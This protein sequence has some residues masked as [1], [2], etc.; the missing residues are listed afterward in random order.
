MPIAGAQP[1]TPQPTAGVA[2]RKRPWYRKKRFMIPL[3]ALIILGMVGGAGAYLI[4]QRFSEFQSVSEPE[5]ESGAA[6]ALTE[7]TAAVTPATDGSIT[8]LMMGVDARDG[9]AIDIGVRPDSLSV[10]HINPETR[11]CRT[12]SIPRDTRTELPGYGQSKINHALSVG[13]VRY[14]QLV[15]QNL[16]GIGVDHFALVDFA[17]VVGAVDALGGVDVVNDTAF[18]MD[19]HQFAVGELHLTGEEALAYSRFRGNDEG[20]FGR[21]RRQQDVIKA[22]LAK[23]DSLDVARAIPSIL[24]SIEGH[25]KT[26][27]SVTQLVRM[28]STYRD[29]CTSTTME[30]ASIDGTVTTAYDEMMQQDLSFV[31]VDLAEIEAKVAWLLGA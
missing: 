26:D 15:V 31:I 10:L 5:P 3:V 17:G 28:A 12:L 30:T 19:G 27:L 4:N 29:Y 25:F 2:R 9:E 21:Q 23:G 16:L 13:G 6:Q 18:E 24:G 1:Y 11:T 22:M 8:I 14:Q 20:D 7:P